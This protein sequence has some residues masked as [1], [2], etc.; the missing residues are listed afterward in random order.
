MFKPTITD[1]GADSSIGN[2]KKKRKNT[3]VR[4]PTT[5]ISAHLLKKTL[6]KETKCFTISLQRR[7][8]R[9]QKRICFLNNILKILLVML[10]YL[11]MYK[12]RGIYY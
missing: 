2:Q 7:F 5:K 4:V 8:V 12:I 3:F 11:I 6:L 1:Y 10:H 9:K